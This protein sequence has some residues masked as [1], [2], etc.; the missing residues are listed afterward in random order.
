MI[1]IQNLT[2]RPGE[3]ES[4]LKKLAARELKCSPADLK[5]FAITKKALDAGKKS[6]IRYVYAVAVTVD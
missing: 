1:V 3:P 6:D 2:L 4:K 5:S